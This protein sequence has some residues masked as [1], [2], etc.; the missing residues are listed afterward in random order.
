MPGDQRD[1][2]ADVS[3]N[4]NVVSAEKYFFNAVIKSKVVISQAA[5]KG[6]ITEGLVE[7]SAKG[8]KDDDLFWF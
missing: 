6:D 1:E 2:I 4:L 5:D 8:S 3:V 7:A